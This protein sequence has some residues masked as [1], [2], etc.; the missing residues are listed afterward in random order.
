MDSLLAKDGKKVGQDVFGEGKTKADHGPVDDAVQHVVEFP[1]KEEHQANKGD[2]FDAFFHE[3]SADAGA[4]E[5]RRQAFFAQGGQGQ[6]KDDFEQD[7]QD[8]G[9]DRAPQKSHRQQPAWL[10]LVAVEPP[11][12]QDVKNGGDQRPQKCDKQD[13]QH[14]SIL[15]SCSG[16]F[17]LNRTIWPP[18]CQHTH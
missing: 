9:R 16:S 8:R 11:D 18:F 10:F 14:V 13:E 15:C 2:T 17:W 1:A 4:D 7:S 6:V 3:G 5:V 12:E